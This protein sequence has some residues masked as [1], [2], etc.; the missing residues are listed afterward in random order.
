MLH[1]DI[2][3]ASG[4]TW[5][6]R[7]HTEHI[8]STCIAYILTTVYVWFIWIRMRQWKLLQHI[9]R[10]SKPPDWVPANVYIFQ[11][12]LHLP[13]SSVVCSWKPAAPGPEW[14]W[15]AWHRPVGRPLG[16]PEHQSVKRTLNTRLIESCKQNK[17]ELWPA[18]KASGLYF[19]LRS[20]FVRPLA[21]SR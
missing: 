20:C 9:W 1:C 6:F 2:Y 17:A 15:S 12:Y 7:F 13:P 3:I 21:V 16:S 11:T 5:S 10:T 18:A 14:S 4:N 19:T 8:Q